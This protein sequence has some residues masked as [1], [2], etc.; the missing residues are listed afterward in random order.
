MLQ[1]TTVWLYDLA[2]IG[3]GCGLLHV[4]PLKTERFWGVCHDPVIILWYYG[5]C[6]HG[7]KQRQA[8]HG[9]TCLQFLIPPLIYKCVCVFGA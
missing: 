6:C 5:F 2:I 1:N 3:H 4:L 9:E 7:T 8:N